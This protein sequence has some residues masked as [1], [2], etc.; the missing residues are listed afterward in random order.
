MGDYVDRGFHS[1]ETFLYVL[2]LKIKHRN[3]ITILRGNH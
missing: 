2:I 3:R 1:V